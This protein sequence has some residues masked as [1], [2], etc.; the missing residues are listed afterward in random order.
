MRKSFMDGP[1]Q[2]V[3]HFCKFVG[4]EMFLS[5]ANYDQAGPWAF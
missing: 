2:I 3:T 1:L 4:Y 5:G